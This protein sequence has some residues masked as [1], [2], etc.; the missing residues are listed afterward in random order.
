MDRLSLSVFTRMLL[1]FPGLLIIPAL[2]TAQPQVVAAPSSEPV[3]CLPCRHSVAATRPVR[4]ASGD[5]RSF[6]LRAAAPTFERNAPFSSAAPRVAPPRRF[7]G[8]IFGATLGAASG[9]VLGA[10]IGEEVASCGPEG[11][12][13]GAF[14]G[15]IIGGVAGAILGG[16]LGARLT[17]DAQSPS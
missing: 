9:V 8:V 10:L 11:P 12:C 2:L 16:L 3:T 13:L 7:W 5:T 6:D 15:A 4:P 1:L 17:K 14:G